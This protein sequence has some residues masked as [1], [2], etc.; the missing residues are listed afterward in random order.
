MQAAALLGYACDEGVRRNMGRTGAKLG[1]D[2]IRNRLAKVANHPGAFSAMHDVGSIVC[3]DGDLEAAQQELSEAVTKLLQNNYFPL[4]LGGGH[5]IA[6]AHYNGIRQF[7]GD[8]RVGIINF[9][10]HFDLRNYEGEATSGTPFYQIASQCKSANLPFHYLCLGVEPLSNIKSLFDTA[11]ALGA[12]YVR[13]EDFTMS[14]IEAIEAQVRR[15]LDDIEILYL[16]I[17]LDGFS[18]AIAPGVS[19]PSPFGFEVPLVL[20]LLDLLM[21]SGKLI[22]M[23]VAELNPKYDR[24]GQTAKLA[25]YLVAHVY[26]GMA[27]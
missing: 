14:N 20:R 25:A 18:A 2:E 12:Q 1:P 7:A 3:E 17:D 10:A 15:F 21:K 5:D 19:A 4:L 11:D 26:Q 16:T 24:D 9:D 13:R 23:D 6:L 27:V 8:K 22:S